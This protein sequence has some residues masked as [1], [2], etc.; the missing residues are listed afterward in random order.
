MMVRTNE[1]IVKRLRQVAEHLEDFRLAVR[2]LAVVAIVTKNREDILH[3]VGV[4][5]EHPM[6]SDQVA[7]A[8]AIIVVTLAK[9]HRLDEAREVAN[10]MVGMSPYWR[11]EALI[12]IVRFSG[13]RV[14]EEAVREMIPQ[15]RTPR[16]RSYAT[17]DLAK[18]LTEYHSGRVPQFTPNI[19]ELNAV[20]AQLEAFDD[21]HVRSPRQS[22]A[23]LRSLATAI[24]DSMF[25]ESMR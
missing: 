19:D 17:A 13:L 2:L 20:M 23:H 7:E 14:D 15:I 4:A 3:A 22:S 1:K 8:L 6:H 18:A 12:F 10:Q 11:T 25:A 5:R 24:I 16:Y 9:A 21:A